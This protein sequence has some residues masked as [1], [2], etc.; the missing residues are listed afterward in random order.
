MDSLWTHFLIK[1]DS[2][3]IQF[4]L[5]WTLK[6]GSKWAQNES[7]KSL[8]LT[9][10]LIMDSLWTHFLV[11]MNSL[12]T[13][14]LLVWTQEMGPKWVHKTFV[15]NKWTHFYGPIFMD[16]F[17]WTHFI[18]PFL[19]P[20]YG[21]IFCDHINKN[22]VHNESISLRSESILSPLWVQLLVI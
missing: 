14:F 7:I 15:A 5:V 18:D 8:I 13:Q 10:G 12:W 11:K 17:L 4:L 22:W 9:N 21:P 16:P 20:F 6:V 19:D 2:L 3:W 1:M